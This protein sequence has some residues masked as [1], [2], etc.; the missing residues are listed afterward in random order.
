[1]RPDFERIKKTTDLVQVV[2]SYG[3][4]LKRAGK[5]HVGFCPFHHD[6]KKPNLH[7]TR[8]TG[9][10]Y[11][12]ACNATGNVIQFVARKEGLTV[13]EAGLKLCGSIPGVQRGSQLVDL[14]AVAS[15]KVD[16][17][18]RAK[19]LARV[20]AF[21]AK[22]L[23]KDRAGLE[24][25]K[26]RR[27]DDPA[28]IETFSVGYCNGSMRNALPK[29][30]ELIEQLQAIGILNA[31]GNE[32][33]YGR[34]VVPIYDDAGNVAGLYG[35]RLSDEEPKHLYLRGERRGVFNS[36]AARTNQSL[37]VTES[38]FDAMSLWSAGLRNVISL[39]G[40]DGW[41]SDH[42]TLVRENGITEIILA[43]DGDARGQEAA[44]ALAAKLASLVKVVH[45]VTW[46]E[47]VKDANDFFLSR[48]AEE[49]R[50][51]LPQPLE[52]ASPNE[53]TT[54]EEKI[55]LTADGFAIAI[56][57]R[58]YELCAIEK[59]SASRLKATIKALSDE[60]AG[61]RFHI[62]TVDFYLSRSRK[63]F[64]AEAAR[65]FR[66]TPDTIEADVNRLIVAVEKYL[67]QKLEGAS[68][69][70][71]TVPDAE[72]LEAMRMGRS[73]GLVDELQRDLAKLGIIGEEGNRLLLYLGLTSRKMEDPLAIQIL[74]SSGAG[75]SHLQDAV[76]SLCPGEDLIKLTS[77]SG[78]ALF[79]KGEDSLRH[80]CLAIAEVAGAEGA[81][82]AL[83]NLI[84]EKK[85]VIE[86]TIKNALSGRLE[87]Q[88][89]IVHGPTA[90]FETTINPDTDPETKS[91]YVLLS[92]DES[93]EQTRAIVE[94]QRQSHTLDGR[95][96]HKV[97]AA[98]IAKH[99]AFQRLLEPVA[100]V[101]PFE[102][103]LSYGDDRLAFRRDHPK[104]LNLILA[105]T[106]LHQ[107]Q[108][109]R[110]HDAELG[111][112]IETTLDDIAIANELA[113]Q[114]FGQSL[115]DLSFPSRQALERISE[116]VE[117]RAAELKT[118]GKKVEFSRRELRETFGWSDTRLRV[119]LRELV[120]LEYLAPVS[121]RNG[122]RFCY[123][124]IDSDALP[125]VRRIAGLKDVETLRQEA[126]LAGLNT[127]PAARNGHP[128]A[129][130]PRQNG[131]VKKGASP[132]ENGSQRSHLAA[133]GGKH[134]YVLRKEPTRTHKKN[135]TE[136][137][138]RAGQAS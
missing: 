16:E 86:S 73:A 106:F 125:G 11:C 85:L 30:G 115:D 78:Q 93:P 132:S 128:A 35:R 81:R 46:P 53:T 97:R 65:L 52:A 120:Q 32:I 119:Y 90:V 89:N 20:V 21:Y 112:Y 5:D 67:A 138:V 131:E 68:I 84:S 76:L 15:A 13:R 91:R 134:I 28:S 127:H 56:D 57:G 24:Y 39:Y 102:P 136:V 43:L 80:K 117:R 60:P 111:D 110:K 101:N 12:G 27:L 8:E 116:H 123:R 69:S 71:I 48:S 54:G 98:L 44:D 108:R 104:Y 88:L 6:T 109:P 100:V 129:T 82:Y 130:S 133:V 99:H 34:V 49:F 107:M 121:G 74:S 50:T 14:S 37:I 36:I 92:V 137:K 64:V 124:L 118:A 113:H 18:T 29:S 70:V 58:A 51:L 31:R 17:A 63:S 126:N 7:V 66:E 42:E 61:S 87:T 62:D 122:L 1:M 23:F 59:P 77:L 72:R 40:K 45:R 135:G 79:Y 10:W 33:F 83:R 3:I 95:K 2:E 114:L 25:L 75:K 38:I 105:V 47:G 19:L 103:L 9:L 41:T 94:A 26:S 96:R 4:A 22:T 55:T